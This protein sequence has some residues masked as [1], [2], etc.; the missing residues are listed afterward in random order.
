MAKR[1]EG[2][3]GARLHRVNP[4]REAPN[5]SGADHIKRN[6]RSPNDNG[7]DGRSEK[8][9]QGV[10]DAVQKAISDVVQLSSTVIEEQI[11]AGQLAAERLRDGIANSKE[12]N[13]DVKLLVENLVATTKDVGATWLD[14]LSIIVR[15]IGSQPPNPPP[16]HGYARSR[17][18]G[19][20]RA[21][22]GTVIQRGTSGSATTIC[23]L[24]PADPES[25]VVPP[26]IVVKGVRVRSATLDL[27]PP[28]LRFV[29]VVRSLV[30][31][32][33]NHGLPAV[34]FELSADQTHLVL[35]VNVPRDQPHGTYT[36]VIVDSSTNEPGGTLSVAVDS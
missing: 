35:T 22:A 33:P 16:P 29:P 36:G 2:R 19:K 21:T 6:A 11:R 8:P 28:S 3:K 4:A 32:D 14:L 7:S 5:R 31:S 30:A 15:S 24:T 34:K 10:S 12:L 25:P 27:R 23:S 26:V 17:E 1:N 13:T 18:S 20:Q 9:K